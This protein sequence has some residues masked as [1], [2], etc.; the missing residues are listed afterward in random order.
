MKKYLLTSFHT[1]IFMMIAICIAGC[2]GSSNPSTPTGRYGD[3]I[4]AKVTFWTT[5]QITGGYIDIYIGGSYKGR[6][7]KYYSNNIGPDCDNADNGG[8]GLSILLPS[9]SY[10]YHAVSADGQLSADGTFTLTPE[11][12]L[13]YLLY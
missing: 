7:T 6:F 9:G 12:C 3:N 5:R 10:Q 8:A 4:T 11:S 2:S 13:K 1:F